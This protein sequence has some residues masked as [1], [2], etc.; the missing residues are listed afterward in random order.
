[1]DLVQDRVAAGGSEAGAGA[2]GVMEAGGP[3][4]ALAVLGVVISTVPS[5]FLP[6]FLRE[7]LGMRV[8]RIMG[9]LR[10]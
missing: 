1:M 5:D 3:A 4:G 7:S 6:A 8:L 2:A 9:W 10:K